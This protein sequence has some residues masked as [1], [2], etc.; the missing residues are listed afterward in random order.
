MVRWS[1]VPLLGA[2]ATA[3]LLAACDVGHAQTYDGRAVGTLYSYAPLNRGL[4][5]NSPYYTYPYS[6]A[7]NGFPTENYAGYAQNRLPTYM[8]S[9]NYPWMYGSYGYFYAPGRWAF[10]AEQSYYTTGPTI[11]GADITL[12]P[13]LTANRVLPD[14]AQTPLNRTATIDVRVPA[15][16]A[17][18]F[19]GVRMNQSGQLRHFVTPQ[20]APGNAYTYDVTASWRENGRE[21][22]RTRNVTI[23]PGDRLEVDMT[24]AA[25]VENPTLRA[26]P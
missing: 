8:T 7:L 18:S 5:M 20:L 13:T 4:T 23:H 12:D 2:L 22:T 1:S 6:P 15:D 19:E 24:T 17:L 9:I 25:P 16:A 10:G 11:Y 14:T 26:R 21:V 3:G